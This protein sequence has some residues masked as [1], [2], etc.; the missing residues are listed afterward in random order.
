MIQQFPEVTDIHLNA[1]AYTLLASLQKRREDT[2]GSSPATKLDVSDLTFDIFDADNAGA[3]DAGADDAG[4]NAAGEDDSGEDDA[5]AGDLGAEDAGDEDAD[6][7]DSGE[8]EAGT[9]SR[10]GEGEIISG[11]EYFFSLESS[12]KKF[13]FYESAAQRV[14]TEAMIGFRPFS[15]MKEKGTNSMLIAGRLLVPESYVDVSTEGALLDLQKINP[16]TIKKLFSIWISSC[17]KIYVIIEDFVNP[18][19]F[20][21]VRACG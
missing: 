7:V 19:G 16:F 2:G 20:Q 5:G 12:S 18:Q 13:L 11:K 3:G 4:A 21:L 14:S 8:D 17:R 15:V 10:H 9:D 1:L 6:A